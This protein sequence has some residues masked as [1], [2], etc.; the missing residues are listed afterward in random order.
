MEENKYV[1]HAKKATTFAVSVGVGAIVKNAL[2]AGSPVYAS[3]NIFTR[4]AVTIGAV[5]LGKMLAEK[6]ADYS[7]RQ[8]DKYVEQ[9]HEGRTLLEKVK[10]QQ[11]KDVIQSET[12]E[13]N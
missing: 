10:L 13:E 1:S 12:T 4:G 5:V 6:A 2:I 11:K 7:D 3:A 9:Y 8:I